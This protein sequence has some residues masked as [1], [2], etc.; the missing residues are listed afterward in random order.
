MNQ[1]TPRIGPYELLAHIK[2]RAPTFYRSSSP[3]IN[4]KHQVELRSSTFCRDHLRPPFICSGKFF[5]FFLSF[6]R[7][8]LPYLLLFWSSASRVHFLGWFLFVWVFLVMYL[9]CKNVCVL[10]LESVFWVKSGY[11]RFVS[12]FLWV[13]S[14]V[15]LG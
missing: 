2:S 7:S 8:S 11:L 12:E 13:L 3:F 15:V 5:F 4:K 14:F 6:P 10:V 1:E 9:S